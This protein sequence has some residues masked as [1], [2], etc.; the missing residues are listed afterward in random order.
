MIRKMAAGGSLIAVAWMASAAANATVISLSLQE[1]GWAPITAS[2][3]TG[4]VSV[5]NTTYGDF[6]LNTVTGLGTPFYMTPELNL[7][8]LDVS[9]SGLMSPETLTIELTETGL[10]SASATAPVLSAFTGNLTGVTDETISTYYDTTDAA[11]GMG[12]L[13]GT[14]NFSAAGSNSL[15]V[16]GMIDATGPY[17]ETA[18]ITAT[19]ASG[20]P[21][22]LD[23]SAHITA[24][25]P[26][27]LAL[28]GLGLLAVGLGRGLRRTRI[29]AYRA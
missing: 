3:S 28:M 18:V 11:Y 24:P 20:G 12:S 1:G 16:G 2:S 27:T 26:S 25:E 4:E 5:V 13:L 7:E 23:S 8:T 10:T 14:A 9:N 21:D 22:T 17:S 19:F 6:T 15:N 29:R